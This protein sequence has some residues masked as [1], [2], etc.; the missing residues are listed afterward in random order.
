MED[1]HRDILKERKGM[2]S[3]KIKIRVEIRTKREREIKVEHP[4]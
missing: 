4:E 1:V 3:I 2:I